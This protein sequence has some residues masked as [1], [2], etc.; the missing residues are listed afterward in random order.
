[1]DGAGGGVVAGDET[2]ELAL[3]DDRQRRR[4]AHFH[5]LQVLDVDRGNAAQDRAA[6]IDRF[7]TR[8]ER[9]RLISH[10]GNDS[11]RVLEIERARLAGDVAGRVTVVYQRREYRIEGFV[12]ALDYI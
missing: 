11:D 2:P 4:G 1:S 10:V 3:V 7:R 9:D 8:A 12:Y 6:E 5:V